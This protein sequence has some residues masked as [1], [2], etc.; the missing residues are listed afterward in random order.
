[1][2]DYEIGDDCPR[3]SHY[4]DYRDCYIVGC[5]DG[6]ISMYEEDPIFYYQD[7]YEKCTNCNGMGFEHWCPN[8]GWD[9]AAVSQA[10]MIEEE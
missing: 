9:A 8:C 1:M 4:T 10:P 3:C 6:L 5:E 2:D 7:D